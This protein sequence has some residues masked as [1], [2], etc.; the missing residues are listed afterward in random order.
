MCHRSGKVPN[1][2]GKSFLCLIPKYITSELHDPLSYRGIAF[3]TVAYKVY[4]TLLNN[5]V[6]SW[7]EHNNIHV[8]FEGQNGFRRGRSTRNHLSSLTNIIETRNKMRKLSFCAFI[9]FKKAYD[10]VS[11]EILISLA[12]MALY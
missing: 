1:V 12:S 5:R 7:C 2:W 3:T 10:T 9:D 4:C 8:I 6:T 11:G